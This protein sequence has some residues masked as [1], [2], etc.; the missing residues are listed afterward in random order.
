MKGKWGRWAW[1]AGLLLAVAGSKPGLAGSNGASCPAG[2]A[3][4]E[5]TVAQLQEALAAGQ[6]TSRCLT[7]I[8]LARIA[9]YDK[10]GP[11][12]NSVLELNPDALAIADKLDRERQAGQVRGP[13]HGIPILIKGNIATHDRMTTTA[14]SVALAGS[15]PENDAFIVER[16][17]AA[18]A[19]ILGKANLTEFANFMSYHM[20]SGYSSEG[21]QTLNPY[22]PKLAGNGLPSL[23]PCGSSAGSG[24]ATAANLTAIS[25]GTETSGSILCPSSFNS[26]VGIKPTLGLVSRSGIIP[27]AH[28][29]DTAGP[30]TRSVADA[31]AL[32]NALAGPDPADPITLTSIGK[33]PADYTEFLNADSLAGARIGIARQYFGGLAPQTLALIQQAIAV[34]KSKGAIVEPVDIPTFQQLVTDNSKVLLYEFKQDLNKYLSTV[35][36]TSPVKNLTQIILFNN[37]N[38]SVALKYGQGLLINSNVQSGNRIT[39]AEAAA[40]RSLDLSLARG[41]LDTVFAEH[42]LDALIFPTYFG[43]DIGAKAGYPTIVVPAGYEPGGAPVGISFL[44]QAFSEPR[45]IGL[46]YA[47]EQA[48][49][50]RRPPRATP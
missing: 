31:A 28:S 23:T 14:G 43:A 13:L 47:Y 5:V 45:L 25:V 46:G 21:G 6:V 30:M 15:I 36:P 27:I 4:Q 41:G 18:G 2:F 40:D 38:R 11:A 3:V 49:K 1:V 37:R 42:Q 39:E 16:L 48:S 22:R 12:I 33:T 10:Q 24:A 20:P 29:Q 8:Y 34:L 50:L 9:R 17:R 32:L 35:G 7:Q 19:V 26:L 44:G